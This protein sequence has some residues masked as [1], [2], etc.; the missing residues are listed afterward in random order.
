[1]RCGVTRG[2]SA[3]SN[4]TTCRNV[5]RGSLSAAPSGSGMD[6]MPPKES[7]G[8]TPATPGTAAM[9]CR[10]ASESSMSKVSGE[11]CTLAR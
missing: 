7:R 5:V 9:R 11:P 8:D 4:A 3:G 6:N 1:M 2:S 10:S